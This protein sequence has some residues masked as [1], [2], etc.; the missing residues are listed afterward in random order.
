M[1]TIFERTSVFP[2]LGKVVSVAALVCLVGCAV[3][4]PNPMELG[5]VQMEVKEGP[6]EFMALQTMSRGAEVLPERGI[7]YIRMEAVRDTAVSVGARTALAWRA[8]HIN[9]MLQTKQENLNTVF[10]FK[11]LLME[12]D[13][14][15]PVLLESRNDMS[16][17][18]PYNIRVADRSYRIA[19]Q[20][21][22][23]SL[24][25]TWRE[26]L[27]MDETRPEPPDHALLP[28]TQ[29]E[30][31]AWQQGIIAGW[32]QGLKQADMIYAENMARLKRDYQGMVRY[33]MLLAQN[34]VSAPQVAHRDLGIT[35]GGE[36][37]SVNDR[38]LTIKALP[39]LK[40]DS[41][42]WTPSVAP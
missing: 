15:P 35:G 39:S 26:Y 31:T 9:R 34:M 33:R 24:A 8:E 12:G 2:K 30:K 32:E 5:T 14:L 38:I 27:I 41:N 40:A 18:G 25:P 6:K 36:A 16:M 28:Q 37:L 17:E 23:V 42:T 1:S 20:A 11:A 7:N 29:E 3:Q 4:A 13:V 22:F 19:K 10:N 21:R